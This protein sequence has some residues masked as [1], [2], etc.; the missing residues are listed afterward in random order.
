MEVC[1][2][3]VSVIIPTYCRSKKIGRAIQSVLNQTY[4]NIEVLVIDDNDPIT[5]ERQETQKEMEKYLNYS[6]VRYVLHQ[7]NLGG[8]KSRNTGIAIAKGDYISFLDDDDWYEPMKIE[9][10]VKMLESLSGKRVGIVYCDMRGLNDYGEQK[11]IHKSR[12]EGLPFVEC[13]TV[14]CIS[15]TSTWLCTKEALHFVEGFP[16]VPCKQDIIMMAMLIAEGFQI[17]NVPQILVNF[18]C[19]SETRISGSPQRAIFGLNAVREFARK[20][21]ASLQ[22]SDIKKIEA[23]NATRL[24]NLYAELGDRENLK[25]ELRIIYRFANTKTKIKYSIKRALAKWQTNN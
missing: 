1:D 17:F 24:F 9:I 3:L 13:V 25:A 10:E 5:L 2:K 12:Y 20:N 6:K 23:I 16:I 11:W 21:Y 4:K 7:R 19:H 8:S 15:P 18:S 22:Q 14:D